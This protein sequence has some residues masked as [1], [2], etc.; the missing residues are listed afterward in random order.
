MVAYTVCAIFGAALFSG[1]WWTI[2]AAFAKIEPPKTAAVV[3]RYFPWLMLNQ[4]EAEENGPVTGVRVFFMVRDENGKFPSNPLNNVRFLVSTPIPRSDA[5]GWH[6]CQLVRSPNYPEW[7]NRDMPSIAVFGRLMLKRESTLLHVTASASNG[8][9]DVIAVLRLIGGKLETRQL[10]QGQF[11]SDDHRLAIDES[12]DGFPPEER[13]APLKWDRA[14]FARY[15]VPSVAGNE[16]G[17]ACQA[18][19]L[20]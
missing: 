18:M 5:D 4:V 1:Y 15:G 19:Q 8:T 17:T 3:H 20:L 12:S 6:E 14:L 9:W 2:Q 13:S 11:F 7:S 16:V 10:L